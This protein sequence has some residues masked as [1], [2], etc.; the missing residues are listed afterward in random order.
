MADKEN[1]AAKLD[2]ISSLKAGQA[3]GVEKKV[4]NFSSHSIERRGSS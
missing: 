2:M 3:A 1:K 4:R